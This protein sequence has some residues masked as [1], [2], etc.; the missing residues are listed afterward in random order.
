MQAPGGGNNTF[1]ISQNY[2]AEINVRTA[3]GSAEQQH[4]G[5]VTNIIPKQGGNI[6]SGIFYSELTN[7]GMQGSN[8]TDALRAQ[9]FTDSS[10]TKNVKM[11]EVS[12]AGG[13]A[14]RQGQA[15]VLRVVSQRRHDPDA[16]RHLREPDAAGLD[17]HARPDAGRPMIKITDTSS[18]ARLTLPGEPL[19]T[20]STF[21]AD[22]PAAHR[23]SA[24]LPVRGVARSHHLHAV[25]AERAQDADVEV[26]AISRLLLEGFLSHHAR[27]HRPAAAGGRSATRDLRLR[28]DDR[29]DVPVGLV[30]PAPAAGNYGP[31][32]NKTWRYGGSAS[33]VT[34]SHS[35]KVGMQ[36][37]HGGERFARRPIATWPTRCE[38]G[39]DLDPAVR[40]SAR[41]GEPHPPGAGAL[42]AGPVDAAGG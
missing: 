33:Y 13:R 16:C 40:R 41:M 42:R 3:G 39:A 9:G 38:T 2:V 7:D 6:F 24:E 1:R 22:Y 21:F 25:P 17:L 15:V 8:L 26:A 35:A 4:G 20:S 14:D 18:S 19:R 34:G 5:T 27:E 32:D 29:H 30:A 23:P 11:W 36:V 10:L 31:F 37:M 12:P 28:D